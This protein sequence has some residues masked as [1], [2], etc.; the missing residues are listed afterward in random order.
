MN[1]TRPR[2]ARLTATL[3]DI[4]TSAEKDALFHFRIQ[5]RMRGQSAPERT[6]HRRGKDVRRHP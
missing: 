3:L 1:N 2:P 5:L 4:L 6:G